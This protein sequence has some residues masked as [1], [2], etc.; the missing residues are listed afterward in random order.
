[1]I[2]FQGQGFMVG[3]QINPISGMPSGFP[4]MFQLHFE[5]SWCLYVK[6]TRIIYR[7]Y[8]FL[9][10]IAGICPRSY[11]G[12]ECRSASWGLSNFDI[13]IIFVVILYPLV[14]VFNVVYSLIQGLLE[15]RQELRPLISKPSNR[16]KDLLFLDIA[17]DSAVRTAVERGYDG[18]NAAG[19]EVIP[20]Y[21]GQYLIFHD[22]FIN[23]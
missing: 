13:G 17:L 5:F 11:W 15:A 7:W 4:V 2:V 1:M 18:L 16:L 9:S 14:F 6:N 19:P 22:K 3:V 23:F 8:I 12:Q 20:P 21:L 10:G